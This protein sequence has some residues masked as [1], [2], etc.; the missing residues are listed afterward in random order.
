[1]KEI[2]VLK[3]IG[4]CQGVKNAIKLANNSLTNNKKCFLLYPLVHNE[5][6]NNNFKNKGL[7]ILVGDNDLS[8]IKKI[9]EDE[10]IILPAHGTCQ[11]I[12]NKLIDKKIK[13][14][15]TICP[16]VKNTFKII[17]KAI[18]NN[19]KIVYVGK[20]NHRET[21]TMLSIDKKIYFYKNLKQLKKEIK[22]KKI[23]IACQTTI[24]HFYYQ[25][26]INNL[27]KFYDVEVLSNP[28]QE[29]IKRQE[30]ILNLKDDIDA[31]FIIGSS[32]SSN[33]KRLYEISKNKFK[34]K[35]IKMVLNLEELKKINIDKFNKIALISGAST[36]DKVVNDIIKYLNK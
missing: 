35:Y 15:D 5:D 23:Y 2:I 8:K 30:N 6:I 12:L 14:V 28:C 33:S 26:L 34:N 1:M 10:T 36:D 20:E 32:T 19:K 17:E 9:K 24:D 18:A 13:Y 16:F 11:K 25:K 31:I 27:R 3:P 29:T 4:L 7:N 22:D 21:L